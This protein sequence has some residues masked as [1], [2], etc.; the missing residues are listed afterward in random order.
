MEEDEVE[1]DTNLVKLETAIRTG[2]HIQ[3]LFSVDKLLAELVAEGTTENAH[4]T[5]GP[6]TSYCRMLVHIM[7]AHPY[8]T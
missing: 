6:M 4:I 5:F 7:V 8:H 2:Q 1:K 3:L